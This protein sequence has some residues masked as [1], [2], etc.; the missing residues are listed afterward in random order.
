MTKIK[1]KSPSGHHDI[2]FKTCYSN[3]Q[4]AFELFQLVLSKEELAVFDWKS[5]KAEKDTF[6]DLR[7]DLVFSVS[8]KNTPN[9][10][11]KLCLLLEHK[12]QFSRQIYHQILKYK[13]LI[14]GNSLEKKEE[15]CLV[16]AIVFYHGKEPWKWAKSLKK[17]L[18]GEILPKIPSSL[19]KDVLDYGIRVLDTHDPQ[20]EKAI[21]DRNFKS[22]GFLATL[23]RVWSLTSEEKELKEVVLLFDNWTGDCV[24]YLPTH[25]I[26]EERLTL[27]NTLIGK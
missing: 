5:L 2:F 11:A 3:P 22:R 12:S 24:P 15:D 25:F 17:G 8:F 14:I 4:F 7:A 13:T 27:R 21:C 1:K 10:K 20:V 18:W 16:I 19:E 23:K 26:T 9:K 6:Q